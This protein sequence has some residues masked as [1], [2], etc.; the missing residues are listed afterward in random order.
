MLK[1]K[2]YTD[3]SNKY[4][5]VELKKAISC[6]LSHLTSDEKDDYSPIERMGAMYELRHLQEFM[7]C[8]EKEGP[9]LPYP[10]NVLY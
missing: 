3:T 4:K 9:K 6:R 1:I 7:R 5:Y 2:S 10:Y 8:L